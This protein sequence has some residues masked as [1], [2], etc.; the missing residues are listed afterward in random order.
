MFRSLQLAACGV[1][2]GMMSV[3]TGFASPINDNFV[4]RVDLGSAFIVNTS[5]GNVD[6]TGEVGEPS[7]SGL[8]NSV[9]WSWTAPATAMVV[10]DTVGSSFDTFLTLAVGL[11]VNALIVL[12]QNDDMPGGGVQSAIGFLALKGTEYQ[13][14]VDGFASSE[15]NIDLNIE[16]IPE[17]ATWMLM[18]R[19]LVALAFIGC[20]RRKQEEASSTT[21]GGMTTPPS[22]VAPPAAAP[23]ASLSG[24]SCSMSGFLVATQFKNYRADTDLWIGGSGRQGP[25]HTL[26]SPGYFPQNGGWEFVSLQASETGSRPRAEPTSPS[27]VRGAPCL[28]A[29]VPA[30]VPK[31][32]LAPSPSVYA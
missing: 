13:L 15:G 11:P 20:R 24:F 9:W 21:Y 6:A 23:A 5:G 29:P 8:I 27:A 12:A 2:L 1:V 30:K 22:P 18:F 19:G 7:Q 17:P 14:A 26:F 32:S 4:D 3:A 16:A 25:S 31:R 10:I 28:R